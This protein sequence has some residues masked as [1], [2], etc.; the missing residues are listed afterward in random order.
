MIK[1]PEE[2][3]N[4]QVI[5]Q[6]FKGHGSSERDYASEVYWCDS[7]DTNQ[8]FWLTSLTTPERRINVS[9]RAID[10]TFHTVWHNDTSKT[11]SL[12]CNWGKLKLEE[13]ELIQAHIAKTGITPY[14]LQL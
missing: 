7:Y 2:F 13:V 5:G 10:R 11:D 3:P 14:S 9:E 6:Y 8:G 1:T 12:Y 4:H